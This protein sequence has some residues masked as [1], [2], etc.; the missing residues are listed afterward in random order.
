MK[1]SD[2]E[3]AARIIRLNALAA[4]RRLHAL[5]ETWGNPSSD[6]RFPTDAQVAAYAATI[7][8]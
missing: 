8:F 2:D 5:T 6:D 1:L 4:L 7:D 3:L